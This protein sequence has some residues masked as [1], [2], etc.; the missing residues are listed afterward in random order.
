VDVGRRHNARAGRVA[1]G[2]RERTLRHEL[3]ERLG[4]CRRS[5]VQGR[6]RDLRENDVEAGDGTRL[7]DAVAHQ[8]GAADADGADLRHEHFPL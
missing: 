2:L 3:V 1:V 8:A 6:L 4:D 5:A 7:C